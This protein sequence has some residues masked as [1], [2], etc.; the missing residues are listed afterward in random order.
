M[1][2]SCLLEDGYGSDHENGERRDCYGD[3][4]DSS[5]KQVGVKACFV[6]GWCRTPHQWKV[7]GRPEDKLV[8]FR[9]L[10]FEGKA[11]RL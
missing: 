4:R 8:F 2:S 11:R 9:S 10:T 3:I 7:R 1:L 5:C 6:A